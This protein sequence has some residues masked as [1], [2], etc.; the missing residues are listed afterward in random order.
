LLAVSLSNPAKGA[1]RVVI[2]ACDILCRM[3]NAT[4]QKKL[5]AMRADIQE[6]KRSVKVNTAVE[7]ARAR[8]RTEILKGLE[9][10]PATEVTPAFWKRMRALAR[11]HA[12]R[13]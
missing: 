11:R 12:R 1:F 10:G 8:L 6:L 9:S 7:K 4:I 2:F 5:A 13:A 3:I